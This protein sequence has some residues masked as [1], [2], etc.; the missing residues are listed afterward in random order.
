MGHILIGHDVADL[1]TCK[2]LDGARRATRGV[3]DRPEI[4]DLDEAERPS[5]GGIS[6]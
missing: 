3:A 5:G 1:A 6:A 2:P 4:H